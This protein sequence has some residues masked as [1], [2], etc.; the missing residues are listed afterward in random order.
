MALLP[1]YLRRYYGYLRTEQGREDRRMKQVKAK[2]SKANGR[3]DR[4]SKPEAFFE[5][6]L[7]HYRYTNYVTSIV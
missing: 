3:I 7:E 4:V 5:I 6:I 2:Q 1:E